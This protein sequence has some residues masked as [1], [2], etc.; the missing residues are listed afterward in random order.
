MNQMYLRQRLI[1]GD[2]SEEILKSKTVVIV[3]CGALGSAVAHLLARMGV[4]TLKLIDGDSVEVHN[5]ARQHL[6]EQKDVGVQKVEA[7]KNHLLAIN[8]E[9]H[10]E[11]LAKY[12]QSSE[13]LT[14]LLPCDLLIDGLD[15]HA[16]RRFVD[17]FCAKE[18]LWWVHGAAIQEKGTI[19]A[20]NGK[21]RKY[22]HIY[23]D[24][25]ADT[26]CA[27]TG[28]LATTT[29]LVASVQTRLALHVLLDEKVPFELVRVA[30]IS[31]TTYPIK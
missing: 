3:G 19:I 15:T 5:L 4:G 31:V 8:P 11:T 9:I 25:A 6:Y 1:L 22:S 30:G 13:E 21:E 12:I 26:H 16:I 28:V 2:A 20:L 18:Q 24:N 17:E 23:A 27:D 7:L 10:I 14:Q 29:T